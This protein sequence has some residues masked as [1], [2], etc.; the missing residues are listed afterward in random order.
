[1]ATPT[2]LESLHDRLDEPGSRGSEECWVDV[3]AR[4]SSDP[5]DRDLSGPRDTRL[6]SVIV[7]K[8]DGG[9]HFVRSRV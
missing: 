3:D 7:S 2:R 9:G 6:K 4:F 5:D 1:M 8:Q